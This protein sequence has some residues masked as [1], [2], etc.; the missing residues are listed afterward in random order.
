MSLIFVRSETFQTTLVH[1][2]EHVFA[3]QHFKK[4]CKESKRNVCRTHCLQNDNNPHSQSRTDCATYFT[5]DHRCPPNPLTRRNLPA[6]FFKIN[7]VYS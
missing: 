3:I 2:K 5:Q 1:A 7:S 6:I 4:I